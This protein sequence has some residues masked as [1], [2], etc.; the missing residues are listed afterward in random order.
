MTQVFV[1]IDENSL[2]FTLAGREVMSIDVE[3]QKLESCGCTYVYWTTPTFWL[4]P[5]VF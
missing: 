1:K 3:W 2:G 5:L 4:E